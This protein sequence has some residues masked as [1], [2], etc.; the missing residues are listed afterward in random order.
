MRCIKNTIYTFVLGT[1]SVF[2]IATCVTSRRILVANRVAEGNGDEHFIVIIQL[3]AR[4]FEGQSDSDSR[5][6]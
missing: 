2:A 6:E 5:R 4:H 1:I 3:A